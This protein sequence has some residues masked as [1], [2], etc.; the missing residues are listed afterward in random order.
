MPLKKRV[1]PSTFLEKAPGEVGAQD[2]TMAQGPRSPPPVWCPG[3]PVG[4]ALRGPPHTPHFL[5]YLLPSSPYQRPTPLLTPL[6]STLVIWWP[7]MNP[8]HEGQPQAHRTWRGSSGPL[9]KQGGM[10]E[11]HSWPPQHPPATLCSTHV[12]ESTC[13]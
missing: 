8:P 5:S 1:C 6:K 11:S 3:L 7:L 9:D 10:R 12:A 2:T 13:V 4:S